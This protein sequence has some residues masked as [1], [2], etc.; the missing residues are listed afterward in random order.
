[1]VAD[2]LGSAAEDVE[3]TPSAGNGSP[4]QE[5]SLAQLVVQEEAQPPCP[6]EPDPL[7]E[8]V[9]DWAVPCR[10]PA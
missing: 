9:S 4:T 3:T 1:M 10:L 8:V 2:L 6:P 7:D 5:I